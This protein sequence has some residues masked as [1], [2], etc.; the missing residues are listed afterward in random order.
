MNKILAIV[1][2]L[3]FFQHV[4][5]HAQEINCNVSVNAE[6]IQATDRRV[7]ET[8]QKDIATFINTRKWTDDAFETEEQI[9]CNVLITLEKG[10]VTGGNYEGSIQIQSLRPVYGTGYESVLIN[11]L[12]RSFQFEYRESIQMNFNENSFLSNLTSVLGYYVNIIIGLDY[13]S[14]SPM[15]GSAYF[16]KARNILN[17]A[18]GSA[19]GWDEGKDYNGRY[20]LQEN[21]NHQQLTEFREGFYKYHRI[22]L[23]SFEENQDEKRKEILEFLKVMRQTNILKPYS[24]I[25]RSFFLAKSDELVGIFSKGDMKAREEALRILRE[26]DP[27]NSEKYQRIMTS[28]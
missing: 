20:W 13:D 14:F 6:K 26:L 22:A 21:M 18:M 19:P 25:I 16:E 12:D 15:G 28:R 27:L 10:S 1:L 8:M 9:K 7:F 4:S 2:L 11:F 17:T 3:T 23:D 24:I 5:I